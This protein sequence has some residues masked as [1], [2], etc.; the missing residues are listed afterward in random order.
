MRTLKKSIAIFLAVLCMFSALSVTSFA[1]TKYKSYDGKYGLMIPVKSDYKTECKTYTINSDTGKLTFSFK[2]KGYKE[3]VYFGLTIYEDEARQKILINKS[4]AFPTVNSKGSMTIDFS[5]LESGTYYGLTFTYIKKG[6]DLVVDN[7]SIYQ[8]DIKLNKIAEITP[9]IT[10]AEALYSGNYIKWDK[11]KYADF[12]RIYRKQEDTDWRQIANVT[13]LEY[14][15]KTAERG[16]KYIY[17]VKA[18]D[19]ECYSKYNKNGVDLIYLAS[20][21]ISDPPETLEDNKIEIS[22]ESVKGAKQYKIYRKASTEKSYTR[23]ATVDGTVTKYVDKTAK[24]DGVTY[25][26]IVRAANGTTTGLASHSM[27][28]TLFATQ[29]PTVSCVGETVTVKWGAVEG[30]ECYKLFKQNTDG[31]WQVLYSGSD[32]F[33]YVDTEVSSGNKYTYSLVVERNGEYSSFDTKGVTVYCLAEPKITSAYSSIDNS[34]YLKWTAVEGAAKYNIYRESPFEEYKFIGTTT[35][36]NFYD[37]LEKENNYF[38]SY[39]VE[40]VNSNSVGISGNN[41]KM[42]LY[43]KAPELTSVKWNSGNVVKWKRVAGAT[44]YKIFRRTPSGSYKEIAEVRDVLS[45]TDKTA[46]KDAQYYYTVTAMNGK[47]KGAYENGI[48]INCLNAPKITSV[49]LNSKKQAVI[50]WNQISGATGYT[51]YRKT[52]DGSWVNLGKTTSLTFTDKTERKSGTEYYYTVRAYDSKGS[53][54]YDKFGK[55][56]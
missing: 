54:L 29:K 14:T 35:K 15:D 31:N 5:P 1:A 40:A 47:Y 41:T 18:Y 9:K 37:T 10:E 11:V 52:A 8:F 45:Y 32:E 34:V 53:G 50:K 25:F 20:P 48:G 42:C 4:G 44:S 49:S 13:T 27:E 36:T 26:Y 43:M 22:W 39:Y 7:D 6:D 56:I 38:Y 23:L 16:E 33:E 12:Y 28:K 2:S 19:G 24:E 51:V 17:T 55:A 30:A 3:N 21:K 46:K